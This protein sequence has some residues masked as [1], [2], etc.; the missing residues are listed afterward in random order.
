MAVGCFLNSLRFGKNLLFNGKSI[1]QEKERDKEKSRAESKG[2][3]GVF[4]SIQT[5]IE[6]LFLAVGGV[7]YSGHKISIYLIHQ[8][9]PIKACQY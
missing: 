9:P 8:R 7:V 1:R 2:D 6:D 5:G 4:F 3:K